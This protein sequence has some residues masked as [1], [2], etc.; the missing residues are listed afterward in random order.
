MGRHEALLSCT[1]RLLALACC[2][3]L[4]GGATAAHGAPAAGELDALHLLRG[5]LA[6]LDRLLTNRCVTPAAN[7]VFEGLKAAGA[8]QRVVHDEFT[9][10]RVGAYPERIELEIQDAAHHPY[11]ITLALRASKSG[12][13]DGQGKHFLFYLEA[14]ASPPSAHATS[15]LLAAASLVD[16]AFPEAALERCAG[17]N[18]PHHDRRYPRALILA[19]AMVELLILIAAIVFGLRA[20]RSP[21]ERSE[22]PRRD[23]G[24]RL[25]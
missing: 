7:R 15:T 13:P 23:D 18:A 21:G 4:L 12:K 9:L 16:E 14:S 25:P 17:G 3:A 6:P 1:R 2:V 20:I 11:A 24:N 10:A 8:F 5:L 19:S 22:A